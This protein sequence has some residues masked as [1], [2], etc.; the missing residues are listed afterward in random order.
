M[1][2]IRVYQGQI[3][4]GQTYINARTGNRQRFS[5]LVRLHADRRTEIDVADA[6]DICGVI[7]LDSVFV[8]D[9]P[10]KI[11]RTDKVVAP[12][13]TNSIRFETSGPHRAN[14]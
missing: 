3:E 14:W 10:D 2:Y 1:T 7:G 11:H 6:G 5:K 4:K 13:T 12:K 8:P 9:T